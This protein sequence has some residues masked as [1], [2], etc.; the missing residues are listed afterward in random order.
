MAMMKRSALLVI[1]LAACATAALGQ[2]S[3]SGGTVTTLGTV[4]AGHCA[5]FASASQIQDAGACG[6]GTGTVVAAAQYSLGCYQ[7]SGSV[8]SISGCLNIATNAAGALIVTSTGAGL[9]QVEIADPGAPAAGSDSLYGNSSYHRW[10]VYNNAVGPLPVGT[11][12]VTSAGGLNVGGATAINGIYT[13][14]LFAGNTSGT[15]VFTENASGLPSW[16][17]LGTIPSSAGYTSNG[18]STIGYDTT[19]GNFHGPIGGADAIIY[20]AASAL[21]INRIP[22]AGSNTQGLFVNSNISDSGTLMT[23]SGTGG[24]SLTGTGEQ[25]ATAQGTVTTSAPFISHTATWNGA[26]AFFNYTSNV[27]CTAAAAASTGFDYQIGGVSQFKL[28]YSAANCATPQLIS[29][30][31]LVLPAG[32]ASTPDIQATGSASNTGIALETTADCWTA[33]GT[34][35]ACLD[36]L[37][38]TVSNT[39]V[40][41]FSSTSTANGTPDTGVDR[42]A[43]GVAEIDVGTQ[44][45]STGLLRTGDVCRITAAVTLSGTTAV[46]CTWSLPA[47][48]AT[49]AWQCMGQY[50]ITAGTTPGLTLQMN[51]SQAPTSETGQAQINVT[52]ATITG[53]SGAATQTTSGVQTI[54]AGGSV[55]TTVSNA[56]W[57]SN[58]TIQASATAGTFAIQGVL[59]GTGTP[60]GTILVGSVCTLN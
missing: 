51:A 32:T 16:S 18:T 43:A 36:N 50:S 40:F 47:A 3:A 57:T 33:T 60:A 17:A 15:G 4:T 12:A 44:G 58:G 48:A 19:A 2:G 55:G 28:N 31:E 20:G 30:G 53:S 24:L 38:A 8:A 7:S 37:G 11:W 52:S 45:A 42:F 13:E 46:I 5:S 9:T 49:W 10:M 34:I 35:T 56:T 1:L 27:T 25:F 14:S 39:K 29:L 54:L 22:K 23:Y 6:T 59:S 21:S 41:L 26:G